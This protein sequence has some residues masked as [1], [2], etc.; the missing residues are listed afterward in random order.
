M[1]RVGLRDFGLYNVLLLLLLL[2]LALWVA[3]RV[4]SLALGL[5]SA[6]EKC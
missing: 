1:I 5:P 2:L 3:F 4:D 6:Y